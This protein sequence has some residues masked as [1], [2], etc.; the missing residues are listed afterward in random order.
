MISGAYPGGRAREPRLCVSAEAP[1]KSAGI[2]SS[3]APEDSRARIGFLKSYS[4][5][6]KNQKSEIQKRNRGKKMARYK[7][8]KKMSIF[9]EPASLEIT[10]AKPTEVQRN[11]DRYAALIAEATRANESHFTNAEWNFM[12]DALCG[13]H[14]D[15]PAASPSGAIVGL[16]EHAHN[17]GGIG[18]RYFPE[19]RAQ[20]HVEALIDKIKAL[21]GVRAWALIH[22]LE[23]REKRGET[24]PGWWLI[25]RRILDLVAEYEIDERV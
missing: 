17:V 5:R 9:P 20:R 14:C 12:A 8:H 2:L 10:G 25:E 3:I 21:S 15:P 24:Q 6:R 1:R 7:T 11:L 22:S 18:A 23:F 16:L 4:K 19:E 13:A